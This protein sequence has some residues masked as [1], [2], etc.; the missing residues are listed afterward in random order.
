MEKRCKKCGKPITPKSKSGLCQACFNRSR[1]ER[2]TKRCKACGTKILEHNKSGLCKQCFFKANQKN[3]REKRKY[4]D[5]N[6]RSIHRQPKLPT[7]PRKC[8]YC[9]KPVGKY[10]LFCN[11]TC[12]RLYYA[13]KPSTWIEDRGYCHYKPMGGF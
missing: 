8:W 7:L 4:Y 3:K 1:R 11:E 10:R 6:F 9:G 13:D 12:R 2:S 5:R